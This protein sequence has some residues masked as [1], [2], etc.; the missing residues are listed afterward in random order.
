[1]DFGPSATTATSVATRRF[2]R[3]SLV[4]YPEN[5]GIFVVFC[6]FAALALGPGLLNAYG[7]YEEEYDRL[8]DNKDGGH[9]TSALGS[10]VIFIGIIQIFLANGTG[11][12]GG[13]C[14]RR[15][16]PGPSVFAGGILM[17]LGL[18]GASYSRQIWQLCLTQGFLFGLGACLVWIPA[19]SAP[20]SWF[21]KN[22]GVATGITHMGLGVGGLVFAP[23]TR[24]LLEKS[25][26]GG[27][28]RW[29]SL[30]ILISITAV[31]LGIHSKHHGLPPFRDKRKRLSD[32]VI[33][34]AR[35]SKCMEDND[36]T[37]LGAGYSLDRNMAYNDFCRKSLIAQVKAGG[38][39]RD[40]DVEEII[41]GLESSAGTQKA[42]DPAAE[43]SDCTCDT[44][45]EI[46]EMAS[47]SDASEHSISQPQAVARFSRHVHF[48][49]EVYRKAA[50]EKLESLAHD[51][52]LFEKRR[53]SRYSQ[54]HYRRSK[55][56]LI[57]HNAGTESFAHNKKAK[58]PS[59]AP[60]EAAEPPISTNLLKSWRFWL[61]SVGVGTGQAAWYIVL[62]FMA[63]V[64]VSVGLDVHN[65]AIVLGSV[66]GASA[67]GQFMAGYAADIVGPVN[68]L[69][70]FTAL[71][72]IS[73]VILF[74][75]RLSLHLLIA[76]ACL[77]GASI[78]AADPL[79]VMANVTQFG[80]ARAATTTGF[81]YGSVGVFVA[82]LVP[83]AR[84]VLETI[85][86][87]K[88]FAPVHVFTIIIF[89]ASS[90]LLLLLRLNI[91]HRLF[92]RV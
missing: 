88:N 70:I 26:T 11:F 92:V 51:D 25:G 67:V 80:R 42:C 12:I 19:A 47:E 73:N 76:Y 6:S 89:A 5:M 74:V 28:L 84:I 21:D 71:A 85:G 10:P 55:H 32:V 77:C 18:L 17:S 86:G 44:D 39:K 20:S 63:S 90:L 24:F 34:G 81:A 69:L 57:S 4:R 35:W 36:D 37:L 16:G 83:N 50:L 82:I 58:E 27:S 46:E 87:G 33:A 91:S 79:A 52:T 53:I 48:A 62:L 68:S 60:K 61:L 66:N 7:V 75:P 15:F 40:T 2:R 8:F 31:S 3:R 78:G 23:V 64:S 14:T 45:A 54:Y 41:I 72:T 38:V 13:H 9:Y 29:L 49:P 56:M 1:M 22:R 65:A 59:P 30:I 43:K